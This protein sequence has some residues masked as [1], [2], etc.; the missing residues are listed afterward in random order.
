MWSSDA[1][2]YDWQAN[3]LLKVSMLFRLNNSHQEKQVGIIQSPP[4]T[5]FY[6]WISPMACGRVCV[7]VSE[8]LTHLFALWFHLWG[9]GA[10]GGGGHWRQQQA[11]RGT[12]LRETVDEVRRS[13]HHIS[14]SSQILSLWLITMVTV[15]HTQRDRT[16]IWMLKIG[17]K[18]HL[19]SIF[20]SFLSVPN[21]QRL[22]PHD[23]KDAFTQYSL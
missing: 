19:C 14:G 2:R 17:E 9:C 15:N 10:G 21:V 3:G 13:S 6:M 23:A 12:E 5:T 18:F 1:L 8:V 20:I 7:C 4:T 22:Y 11:K 16:L